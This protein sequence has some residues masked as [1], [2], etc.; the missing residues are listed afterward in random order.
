MEKLDDKHAVVDLSTLATITG[1]QAVDLTEGRVE[2]VE[3]AADG[4]EVRR[5]ASYPAGLKI[6]RKR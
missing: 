3:R 2:I 6:V 4:T 5:T 1:A